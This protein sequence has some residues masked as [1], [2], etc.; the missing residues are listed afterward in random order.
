M[1]AAISFIFLQFS[2][3][4]DKNFIAPIIYNFKELFFFHQITVFCEPHHFASYVELKIWHCLIKQFLVLYF[5]CIRV[6]N[7]D[8]E[9]L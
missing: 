7:D 1:L 9:L 3:V 8:V 2:N 6:K 5:E 4:A